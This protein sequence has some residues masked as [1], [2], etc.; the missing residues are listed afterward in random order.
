M[1]NGT[2]GHHTETVVADLGQYGGVRVTVTYEIDAAVY[3]PGTGAG[4]WVA[5]RPTMVHLD[6][7]TGDRIDRAVG[8]GR[9]GPAT[10]TQ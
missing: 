6:M 9:P 3:A 8:T 7:E 5:L 2:V 4:G 10:S 1:N